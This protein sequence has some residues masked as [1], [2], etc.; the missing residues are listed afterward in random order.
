M[1]EKIEYS[2]WGNANAAVKTRKVASTE[3]QESFELTSAHKDSASRT[4]SPQQT[5]E[6]FQQSEHRTGARQ[7][8]SQ[9]GT[10]TLSLHSEH[11][12]GPESFHGKIEKQYS[13]LK[14]NG[15]RLLSLFN[16]GWAF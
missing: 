2:H 1:G 16:A 4:A 7:A 10:V 13:I 14:E 9:H 12:A 5:P 6:V 3:V 11:I 8:Q 15:K